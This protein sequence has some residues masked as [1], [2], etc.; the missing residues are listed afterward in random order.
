[1]FELPDDEAFLQAVK[2]RN[3]RVI[4]LAE[5]W[6]G[7]CML[8]IPV[9]L[10]LAEKTNMPVRILP[11]DEIL[12]LMDQYLTDEKRIIPIFIVIDES[13]NEVAK[14]GPKTDST[15]QFVKKHTADLPPKDTEDYEEK[16]KQ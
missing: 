11:R 15:D 1:Q 12:E 9:L 3:L 8:N 5:G 7:H 6:C 4:V 13:G 16:F 2:E 10:R 14:W